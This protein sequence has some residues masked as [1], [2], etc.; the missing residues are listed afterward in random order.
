MG[1]RKWRV[2]RRESRE[3]AFWFTCGLR[4]LIEKGEMKRQTPQDTRM[5]RILPRVSK[6]L[7]W[8]ALLF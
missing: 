1:V 8:V 5:N 3:E 4:C 7:S 2:G 6:F